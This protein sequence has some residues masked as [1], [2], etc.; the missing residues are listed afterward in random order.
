LIL[1]QVLYDDLYSRMM[2]YPTLSYRK[3]GKVSSHPGFSG[4]ELCIWDYKGLR[5]IIGTKKSP[6][7]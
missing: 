7:H 5:T 3:F 1:L 6:G 2:L 4:G